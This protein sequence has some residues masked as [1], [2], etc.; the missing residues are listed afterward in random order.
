MI[1]YKLFYTNNEWLPRENRGIWLW[2][3]T[4]DGHPKVPSSSL[5]PLV[6]HRMR[7][8][9]E[10][11]KDYGGFVNLLDTMANEDISSKFRR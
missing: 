11:T 8:F 2:Q 1:Q 10:V 4:I 6:S 9:D 7:N 5:V 3:E